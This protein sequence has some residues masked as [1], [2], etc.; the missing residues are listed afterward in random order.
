MVRGL[1]QQ[2]GARL[3]REWLPPYFEFDPPGAIAR[4]FPTL[5]L[6]QPA[7]RPAPVSVAQVE[8][9]LGDG[10][11]AY[12]TLKTAASSGFPPFAA[13]F[14][15]SLTVAQKERVLAALNGREGF[16]T[17]TY[18]GALTATVVATATI[19]GDVYDDIAELGR[20]PALAKCLAQVAR[21][22]ELGRLTL[23]ISETEA[24]A[25]LRERAADQARSKA[26]RVM[27]RMAG[28][29]A[30]SSW[31]RPASATAALTA[32]ARLEDTVQLPIERRADISAWFAS[33]GGAD[34]IRVVGA[35]LPDPRPAPADAPNV[36]LGFDPHGAPIAFVEL[37]RGAAQS[38]L[39]GPSFTAATLPAGAEGP[40]IVTTHY[41]AAGAP[42]T[43]VNYQPAE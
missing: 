31:S 35:T 1:G 41:T 19:A 29:A 15:V 38:T 10:Q 24:P 9:A 11:G 6:A 20:A 37:A 14:A 43:S 13:I 34:Q 3:L 42:D 18:R 27:L 26:A 33:G 23:E 21:A 22:L 32:T 16:L 17:V 8:L 39:R 12:E 36:A 4:R 5:A 25:E 7:L 40:L 2:P 28:D 30:T